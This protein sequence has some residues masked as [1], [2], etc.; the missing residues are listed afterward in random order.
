MNVQG[1]RVF[2]PT[3]D[4]YMWCMRPFSYL[5]N[6][7]WGD[8]QQV[9]FGGFT[10]P[11]F[12]L[13]QNFR[14]YQIDKY[15]YPPNKWSNQ[16]I[17]MLTD[18]PDEYIVLLLEDYW[19][20]RPVDVRGVSACFEYMKS[21]PRVLRVDLTDDRQYAGGVYDVDTIGS[22]DIVETSP[23]TPYQFST[24]A[25]IWRKSLLLNL[26]VPDK[27]AWEVEIHT[28]PPGSMRVLGTRQRPISY[29]NAMLKGKI[30]KKQLTKI[31]PTL[32]EV[33]D[34]WIPPEIE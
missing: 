12:P 7:M 23:S 17:K 8:N 26:L 20:N 28:S 15:D 1:L 13:P 19:L 25:G 34:K 31:N 16:I 24:Q 27:S 6:K 30:D 4:K 21:R 18:F 3:C 14:F 10:P 9:V 32:R 5:F 33:I 22:Y 29:A 2:V 11:N